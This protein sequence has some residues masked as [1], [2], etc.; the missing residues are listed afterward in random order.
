ML[1]LFFVLMLYNVTKGLVNAFAELDDKIE[2]RFCLRYM[3]ANFKKKDLE[4]E[5]CL[6]S[7]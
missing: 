2:H 6:E 5:L 4:E 1:F 3:Y 7:W